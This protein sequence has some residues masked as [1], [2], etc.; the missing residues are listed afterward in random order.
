MTAPSPPRE[1]KLIDIR[2][3]WP[4]E[5]KDFTPWLADNLEALSDHLAIGELERD[6]T[7]VEIPGGRR[8]DILAKDADGRNWAI[9]N[10][11]G[12]ADHDHLT[13]ALAY[14][15][16][17]ECRA[18]IVVAS[19]TGRS[20]WPWPTSGTGTRRPTVRRASG[21]SWSPSKQAG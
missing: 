20:S 18:V 19:P 16:G 4:G 2:E 13:R 12:E 9:E 21:C 1:F 7:E 8:L 15:V 6:S 10:Q 11:Y 14:A 17:L 3:V 5:A